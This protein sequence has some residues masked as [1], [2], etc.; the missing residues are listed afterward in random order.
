MQLENGDP[1]SDVMSDIDGDITA[2]G[3]VEITISEY[4]EGEWV[5]TYIFPSGL[6]AS[7]IDASFGSLEEAVM[8]ILKTHVGESNAIRSVIAKG[9]INPESKNNDGEPLVLLITECRH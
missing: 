7:F 5:P 9:Y 8:T 2:Q 6:E 4:E 3:I 1:L